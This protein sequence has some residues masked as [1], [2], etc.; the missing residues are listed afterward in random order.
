LTDYAAASVCN[1]T[2]EDVVTD[3]T[4]KLA[5]CGSDTVVLSTYGCR[6]GL[7]GDQTNVVTWANFA[8]GEEDTGYC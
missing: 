8:E 2:G 6:A 1:E 7:R 4:A 5:E 3:E